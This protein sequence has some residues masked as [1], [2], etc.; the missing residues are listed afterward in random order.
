VPQR[1]FEERTLVRA[2]LAG[3]KQASKR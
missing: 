2:G 3:G 1:V